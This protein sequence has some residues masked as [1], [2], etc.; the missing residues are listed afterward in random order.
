MLKPQTHESPKNKTGQGKKL[1]GKKTLLDQDTPR[2]FAIPSRLNPYQS[3]RSSGILGS[4]SYGAPLSD[5]L[6]VPTAEQTFHVQASRNSGTD[7]QGFKL[8][9]ANTAM[10]QPF[11][12]TPGNA[13]DAYDLPKTYVEQIRWSRLM[14]NLNAYIA[15][16]TDLKAFYAYSKFKLITPEPSVTEFYSQVAF[17]KNFN[18]YDHILR[19]SLNKEKFGE[20]ISWGARK[21]AGVWPKTGQPIWVWDYFI[22]LEPELVEIKKALI[23]S[24]KPKFFLRPNRDMEELIDKIESGDQ[25]YAAMSNKIPDSIRELVKKKQQIQL[26]ENTV[27]CIQNLTDASATRG[28]PPY[29][30]LYTTFVFEDFIRLAHGAHAK[31]YHFPMELWTLGDLGTNLLPDAA[32]LALLRDQVNDAIQNP[33]F[34]MFLPPIVKYEALGVQGKTYPFVEDYEYI[35]KMYMIGMGVSDD[36]ILGSSNMFGSAET[37]S[38]QAFVRARKKDRDQMEDWM[39]WNFF[40]PLARWNNLKIKKGNVLA[41]I[42][43]DYEW[44]KVLD[45]T[46]EE[47]ER[48]D[49]KYM[50][51]K[52]I[53]PAKRLI[54]KLGENPDGVEKEMEAELFT[55]LDDGKRVA[56]P[57]IRKRRDTPTADASG[58]TSESPIGG[59]DEKP[60]GG[61]GGGGSKPSAA[62]KE[63]KGVGDEAAKAEAPKEEAAPAAAEP[64][65]TEKPEIL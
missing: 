44:E 53:Y 48:E 22:L 16:I 37:S 9:A 61:G 11:F 5:G 21:Q 31:R 32:S 62:P 15:A 57:A 26:D 28:T 13:Q 8:T 19:K 63:E 50:Y 4:S 10:T 17:N 45:F 33:P 52:G 27:S 25:E 30:R 56:A 42:L 2:Q 39:T 36:L 59:K 24:H 40:E 29:Q 6:I 1:R 65:I 43:P 3:V 64:T 51:E 55:V 35:H 47:Q 14:Y 34:S 38:N 7:G 46:A 58:A 20:A 54:S 60:T 18:L 49:A 12:H 23:G 41:P